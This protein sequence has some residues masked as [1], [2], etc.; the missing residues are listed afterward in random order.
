MQSEKLSRAQLLEAMTQLQN[1]LEALKAEKADL[2]ILLETTTEHSDAIA[3]ELQHTLAFLTAI[4]DNLA[5]GLLVTMPDGRI[6]HINPALMTMF[7]LPED[8]DFVGQDYHALFGDA[9]V[10]LIAETASSCHGTFI[11]EISLPGQ[12]IGKAVATAIL[13]DRASQVT[14]DHEIEDDCFET[15][16]N[17]NAAI[18][19]PEGALGS[20]SIGSVVLIRDITADKE[21]DRMKT[22]FISTVSHELRTPLTS[23][24]GFA[25]IIQKRLGENIFPFLESSQDRKLQRS[26]RQVDENLK[27]IVSEGIRLT[28][29]INDVLD[30]AKMEAGKVDWHMTRLEIPEI[31][32]AGMAATS[33]LFAQKPALRP[34]SEVSGNLPSVVGDRDRLIQVVINLISNAVKFTE[35]GSVTCQASQE[36]DFIVVR[37]IDTGAGIAASDLDQV[38]D[39]FKQVGDTLTDKPKGTGLG[40]SICKQI[41]EYHGGRIWVESELGQG[42]TFIFTLPLKSNHEV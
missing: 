22:D 18:T 28:A 41:I 7:A 32:N 6:S 23:V 19:E 8:Q 20:T 25:K 38:F 15:E 27:I 3:G 30:V 1:E 24:L 11:A 36:D 33:A 31:I 40:L 4:M 21:V 13:S 35:K 2:E 16:G 39:K 5:D 42:S 10:D 29:L 26:L 37:I 14:D 12:R 17:V 9:I 34:I